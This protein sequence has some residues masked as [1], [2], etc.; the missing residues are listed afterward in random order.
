MNPALGI[1]TVAPAWYDD[2]NDHG[3]YY[4]RKEWP[5]LFAQGI[6]LWFYESNSK[7]PPYPTFATNT[8]DGMEPVML[9]WGSW[10]EGATGFLEWDIAA[11]DTTD[12]WGPE[13]VW[14]KTGDGVLIYPGNHDGQLAPAGSPDGVAMDGPV[15]SFRLK[16][17]RTGL[18]DWALF[19]LA[20]TLGLG[21][22]ARQQ[23]SQAYGQLGG[24][25]YSGCPAP[26]AGF[27]WK[28][29]EDVMATIRRTVAQA[30]IA[31]Q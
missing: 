22:M 16:M 19:H 31:K 29:D 26:A 21:D 24:C 4:G 8:L 17:L 10:Y 5:A 13:I 11:W 28:T 7:P 27:Y 9:M 14:G 20:D 3:P 25:S 12:P 15:P 2:W 6:K 18:Q 30:I 1:Y 23:V